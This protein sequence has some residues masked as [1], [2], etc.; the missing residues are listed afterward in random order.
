MNLDKTASASKSGVLVCYRDTQKHQ[1]IPYEDIQVDRHIPLRGVSKYQQVEFKSFNLTQQKLYN[2]VVYGLD[3]YPEKEILEMSKTRKRKIVQTFERTQRLLNHWKQE[4]I[5]ETIDEFFVK[6]FPK[7]RAAIAFA[8]VKGVD[9]NV[10][11]K[12]SFKELKISKPMIASKLIEFNILPLNFF[13]LS[14]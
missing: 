5:N 11:N 10:K 4:I 9:S 2:E 12:S 6:W 13:E 8:S 3:S 1:W 7:S 14:V